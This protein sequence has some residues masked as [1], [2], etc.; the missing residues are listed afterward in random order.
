MEIAKIIYKG[1]LRTEA[2]HLKSGQTVVTDAPVD[3][4]GKGEAFSPTDLMSTSLGSC[5]L[6]IMGIAAQ[7]HEIGIGNVEVEIG[8]HMASDP[9]R[10]SQID[11]IMK[12]EDKGL[13]DKEKKIL[14]NSALTCPVA[15]S[16]SAEIIQNVSFQYVKG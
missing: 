2:T 1:N 12:I 6:T 16:L 11:V 9:R 4:Q 14:E 15:K 7:K 10:V 5:M 13:T 8:K 3:N